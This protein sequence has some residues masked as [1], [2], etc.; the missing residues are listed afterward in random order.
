MSH[1][2]YIVYYLSLQKGMDLLGQINK[3]YA[4]KSKR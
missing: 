1:V 2:E 3:E 4:K